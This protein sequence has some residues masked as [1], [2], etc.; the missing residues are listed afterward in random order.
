MTLNSTLLGGKDET[1]FEKINADFLAENVKTLSEQLVREDQKKKMFNADLQSQRIMLYQFFFISYLLSICTRQVVLRAHE[2]AMTEDQR[3]DMR[4]LAQKIYTINMK[5]LEALGDPKLNQALD[6]SIIDRVK[7]FQSM[8]QL[9]P[10]KITS[11]NSKQGDSL[12]PTGG[13][14]TSKRSRKKPKVTTTEPKDSATMTIIKIIMHNLQQLF[15]VSHDV[16]VR[17]LNK[18]SE[19]GAPIPDS[20]SDK[21]AFQHK[22]Q[23]VEIDDVQFDQL[24]RLLC[25]NETHGEIVTKMYTIM[26]GLLDASSCSGL[27]MKNLTVLDN[28]K[29]LLQVSI[30]H[31]SIY[32]CVEAF[33]FLKKLVTLSDKYA[34]KG[35]IEAS[36]AK[37]MPPSLKK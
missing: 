23:I 4:P 36:L 19:D 18:L 15:R 17:F 20:K 10:S 14:S 21:A 8:N 31:S 3:S 26:S 16:Q 11:P 9:A 12:S 29:S 27:G 25:Q 33:G 6:E 1:A 35:D 13:Q 30:K 7:V 37:I 34:N 22:M 32:Q 5:V 2:K 24:V 28:S